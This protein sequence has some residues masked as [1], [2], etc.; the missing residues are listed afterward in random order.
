MVLVLINV[1]NTKMT[2]MLCMFRSANR[3]LE[4][5]PSHTYMREHTHMDAQIHTHTRAHTHM[6]KH[7]HMHTHTPIPPP[8][9]AEITLPLIL[10]SMV[11]MENKT[12]APGMSQ[13]TCQC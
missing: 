8:I 10:V 11:S 1:S 12:M 5:D 6:Q 3:D 7:A 9:S 13:L 2:V 4:R